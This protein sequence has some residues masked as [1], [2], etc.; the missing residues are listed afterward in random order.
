[1][2]ECRGP[3]V[4][5]SNAVADRLLNDETDARHAVDASDLEDLQLSNWISVYSE[6]RW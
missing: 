4:R 3:R 2:L 6:T 5:W 1:M